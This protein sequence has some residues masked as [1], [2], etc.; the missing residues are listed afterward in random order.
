MHDQNHLVHF[1]GVHGGHHVRDV[2]FKI[3]A[4]VQQMGTLTQPGQ[5]HSMDAVPGTHQTRQDPLPTPGTM[6]SAMNK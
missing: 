2:T 1:F 5:G 4:R 3:N 6:P